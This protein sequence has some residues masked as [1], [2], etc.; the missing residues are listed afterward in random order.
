VRVL[1]ALFTYFDDDQPGW[2]F[3]LVVDSVPHFISGIVLTAAYVTQIPLSNVT[4]WICGVLR[5]RDTLV[6]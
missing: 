2:R 3:R 5:L 6:C 1:R 4:H